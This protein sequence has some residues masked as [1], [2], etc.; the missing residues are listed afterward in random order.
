MCGWS[1]FSVKTDEFHP[2]NRSYSSR[3]LRSR[4][5][6]FCSEAICFE[7][8]RWNEKSE[9][10]G[11]ARAIVELECTV[12]LTKEPQS[13]RFLDHESVV[14]SVQWRQTSAI[15]PFLIL[16]KS[17]S[18]HYFNLSL[19]RWICKL[20]ES[21]DVFNS[22]SADADEL[23]EHVSSSSVPPSSLCRSWAAGRSSI[24]RSFMIL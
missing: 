9:V 21:T 12:F 10:S 24:D 1:N 18:S 11:T 3:C 7:F 16:W 13:R 14:A 20:W 5:A 17:H 22:L 2:P 8:V 6:S 19:D 4:P 15:A 23:S